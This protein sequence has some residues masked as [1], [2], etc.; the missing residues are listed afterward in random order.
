MNALFILYI[1]KNLKSCIEKKKREREKE[2][3]KLGEVGVNP[4]QY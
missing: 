4:D 3:K 1:D 2:E